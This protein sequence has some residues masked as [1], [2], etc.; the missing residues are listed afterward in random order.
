MAQQCIWASAPGRT[1]NVHISDAGWSEKSVQMSDS[2]GIGVGSAR[3]AVCDACGATIGIFISGRWFDVLHL[4][5]G[6]VGYQ[7]APFARFGEQ[8]G[9]SVE[10]NSSGVGKKVRV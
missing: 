5:R 1:G 9:A 4:S 7:E 6:R 8:R 3:Q 10:N 2:S